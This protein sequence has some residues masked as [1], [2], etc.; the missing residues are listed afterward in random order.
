M[1]YHIIHSHSFCPGSSSQHS[2]QTSTQVLYTANTQ[3]HYP[4]HFEINV[5]FMVPCYVQET[6]KIK[7]GPALGAVTI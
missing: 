7:L 5:M 4:F 1:N 3:I 6:E 2:I